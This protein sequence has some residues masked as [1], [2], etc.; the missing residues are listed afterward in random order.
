MTELGARARSELRG[1]CYHRYLVTE[2]ALTPCEIRQFRR[3]HNVS[4]KMVGSL[5]SCYPRNEPR[6]RIRDAEEAIEQRCS[7]DGKISADERVVL[8]DA[9]TGLIVLRQEHRDSLRRGE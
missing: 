3:C 2:S 1:Y 5:P 6:Q 8:G 4:S 7:L 9:L